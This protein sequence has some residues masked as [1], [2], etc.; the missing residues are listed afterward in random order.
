MK[1][2]GLIVL[3]FFFL[4]GC[5]VEVQEGLLNNERYLNKRYCLGETYDNSGIWL[6]HPNPPYDS[7]LPA[8][9]QLPRGCMF[10]FQK[11]DYLAFDSTVVIA[12][13][14]NGRKKVFFI[15]TIRRWG[16]PPEYLWSQF[17][18]SLTFISKKKELGIPDSLILKKIPVIVPYKDSLRA[19]VKIGK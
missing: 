8:N 10:I 11:P 1:G 12:E 5:M 4:S 3:I 2:R 7:M 13:R 15:G 19:P 14:I 6:L 16:N 9:Q 18:D 17:K